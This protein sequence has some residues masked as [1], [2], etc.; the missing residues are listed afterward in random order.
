MNMP[1]NIVCELR[2]AAKD[3]VDKVGV[4]EAC[5]KFGRSQK[6]MY[7]LMEGQYDSLRIDEAMENG[8]LYYGYGIT[9]IRTEPVDMFPGDFKSQWEQVCR[10]LN[11]A[12]WEVKHDELP[13]LRSTS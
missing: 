9:V 7:S 3:I 12:A 13:E 11:P 4:T 1:S 8:F 10:K 6:W 2:E 5:R